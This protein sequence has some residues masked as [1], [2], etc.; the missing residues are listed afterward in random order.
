MLNVKIQ[1]K[2]G[3]LEVKF[4]IITLEYIGGERQMVKCEPVIVWGAKSGGGCGCWTWKI[5]QP[6]LSNNITF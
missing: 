2:K 6:V 1:S 3:L 4:E 5:N